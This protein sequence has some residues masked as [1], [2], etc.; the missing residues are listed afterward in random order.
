VKAGGDPDTQR[1]CCGC[2]QVLPRAAFHR[3]AASQAGV[4]SKCRECVSAYDHWKYSRST[5][6]A[7]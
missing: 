5:G 4:A 3:R 7:R 1:V 6:R 2:R